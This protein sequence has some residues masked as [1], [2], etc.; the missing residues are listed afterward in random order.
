M[1]NWFKLDNAAT[2]YPS[3]TNSKN[4][5][6]FRVSIYLNDLVD[7]DVLEKE[8]IPKLMKRFP[9]FMVHLK[10]GFFWYYFEKNNTKPKLHREW[11]YPALSNSINKDFYLLKIIPYKNRI[12]VES[13]HILTD[14]YGIMYFLNTLAIEY[15]NHRYNIKDSCKLL[16]SEEKVTKDEIVDSFLQFKKST[17]K[18]P[19]GLKEA[20]TI[21]YKP[22]NDS[23]RYDICR[24]IIPLSQTKEIT[25]KLKVSI[26]DFLVAIHI[27]SLQKIL[28]KHNPKKILPIRAVVPINLRNI[29]PSKTLRN[30]SF[31]I[32]PEIDNR[33]G[34]YS[35]EEILKI[36]HHQ[37]RF[38]NTEKQLK[39][40]LTRNI[41]SQ[42]FPLVRYMPLFLKDLILRIAYDSIGN[43]PVTSSLSNFGLV[44]LPIEYSKYI[45]SYDF[46]PSPDKSLKINVG[47]I[48]YEKEI[49]I[50][51]GKKVKETLYERCFIRKLREFGIDIQVQTNWR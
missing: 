26:N 23:R 17:K 12:S 21:P 42:Y 38:E 8:I 2:I 41:D 29:F 45:K 10:R 11:K 6:T 22:F 37:I 1:S 49:I 3:I 27:Y 18:K 7:I 14:G 15:I 50:N 28:L 34:K 13:S 31:I 36:V 40:H 9:Y 16:P 39:P 51:I 30:F 43:K 5:N 46:I 20:Y 44:K 4:P 35:F 25:K 33:L 47:T 32:T 48:S 24:I 19:L